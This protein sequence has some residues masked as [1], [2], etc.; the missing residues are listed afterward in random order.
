MDGQPVVT[1]WA[2]MKEH[3]SQGLSSWSST[4]NRVGSRPFG[5]KHGFESG[6]DFLAETLLPTV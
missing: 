3:V 5:M 6:Q 4:S 2:D 1:E